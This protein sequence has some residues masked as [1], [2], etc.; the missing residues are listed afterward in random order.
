MSRPG[1]AVL[2]GSVKVELLSNSRVQSPPFKMAMRRAYNERF[3]YSDPFA[4]ASRSTRHRML[5]RKRPD[6]GG[7]HEG[8]VTTIRTEVVVPDGVD[9]SGVGSTPNTID[10]CAVVTATMDYLTSG[11]EAESDASLD[12]EPVTTNVPDINDHSSQCS[13]GIN[14]LSECDPGDEVAM[15]DC[16]QELSSGPFCTNEMQ[17]GTCL[18]FN[19]CPL[20][21]ATSTLLIKKFQMRHGLTN[22]GLGDL[23]QL[24]RLH[25]P[26][27]N[28]FPTS[29]YHFNKEI[30]VLRE[31]LEFNYYCSSCLQEIDKNES[32][33]PNGSCQKSL[34]AKGAI[35]SFIEVPLEPQLITVLQ[36]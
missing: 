35:S 32:R 10:D 14:D 23:L 22:E 31:P 36:S 21:V 16:F 20:T 6:W 1:T 28:R 9:A 11:L 17:Q 8:E 33:C 19:D 2:A 5:K 18:V 3:R 15:A 29:L 7:S 24:I 25:F 26:S 12:R 27:P 13:E 34:T 4:S 30:P